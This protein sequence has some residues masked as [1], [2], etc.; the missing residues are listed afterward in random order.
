[1]AELNDNY[2]I[3]NLMVSLKQT[4]KMQEKLCGNDEEMLL[5]AAL[6]MQSALRIYRLN[7]GNKETKKVLRECLDLIPD[8]ENRK[9]H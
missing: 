9:L 7:I 4:I 8:S 6:Q 2:L 3:D 1:M 5:L